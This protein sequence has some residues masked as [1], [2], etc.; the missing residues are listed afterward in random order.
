MSTERD[1]G[2]AALQQGNVT[3]AVPLLEAACQQDPNDY[4]AH[5][6]LG[7][8]YAQAG[9][10]NDSV[11]VLTRAVQIEPGNAQARYNLGIALEKAGWPE[12]ALT[13]VQQA[14][15]LQPDY[16]KAQEAAARLSSAGGVLPT[17]AMPAPQPGGA[18]GYAPPSQATVQG[19]P[20]PTG[21][22]GYGQ[23]PGAQPQP[24]YGTPGPGTPNYA[25]PRP[26]Y[27]ATP[28]QPM[29][30]PYYEDNFD[31]MQAF[32]DWG[33][34]LMS[35]QQFFNDQVGRDGL[36]APMAMFVVFI[37]VGSIL[38]LVMSV[39]KPTM[40]G[41]PMFTLIGIGIRFF[42]NLLIL[43]FAALLVHGI[44]KWFGN[45]A[46]YAG[47]FRALVY[48]SAPVHTLGLIMAILAPFFVPSVTQTTTP[49][50]YAP[51]AQER[52]RVIPAQF[53]DQQPGRMG[54][55][56]PG[57]PPGFGE[58]QS[59][60]SVEGPFGM[61]RRSPGGDPSA[62]FGPMLA[63]GAMGMIIGLVEFVWSLILLVLGLSAIQRISA[64][65]ALGTVILTCVVMLGLLLLISVV[66][67]MLIAGL[68]LS[69]GGRG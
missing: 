28:I 21:L 32:K 37:A 7:A 31:I 58:M 66:F 53:G 22:A 8:A 51:P 17:Q 2:L 1:Q 6:Y 14:L 35:P 3:E 26:A 9:R 19:G 23:A 42:I 10:H 49:F 27:S 55:A 69:G 30:T 48:S 5:L 36:K 24:G 54:G 56:Q 38:Q 13:A 52:V 59:G 68:V 20:P 60:Q 12:Q 47:S 43:L 57:M 18:P 45:S 33:R 29:G 50:G 41:A 34:V 64:G 65:A 25:P 46:P 61:K 62:M 11:Q 15:T 63:M 4:Q 39:L 40:P 16:P 67:G 44:G